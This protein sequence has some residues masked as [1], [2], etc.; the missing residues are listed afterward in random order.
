MPS[1]AAAPPPP[2]P[3][4]RLLTFFVLYLPARPNLFSDNSSSSSPLKP[5][6]F[7]SSPSCLPVA[8]F[9][10][11]FHLCTRQNEAHLCLPSRCVLYLIVLKRQ[12]V[13]V[14]ASVH[15]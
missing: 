15:V 8:P 9:P 13:F 4:H 1:P 5:S 3:L 2:A 6:S 11:H 7:P 12:C 10:P 14:S